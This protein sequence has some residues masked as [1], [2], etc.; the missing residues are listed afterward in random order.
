[1]EHKNLQQHVVD[2]LESY[3]KYPDKKDVK[4]FLIQ[5]MLGSR[6]YTDAAAAAAAAEISDT[7]DG[8]DEAYRSLQ[9]GK[10]QGR[11]RE[12][13]LQSELEKVAASAP[14]GASGESVAEIAASLARA[15][16][17][18]VIAL[19]APAPLFE[20]LD[21]RV[22]TKS[23]HEAVHENAVRGALA[24]EESLGA[25]GS[26]G[27]K[28]I[29]A[30]RDYLQSPLDGP[31]DAA[32][33]K[34]VSG[35]VD[36]SRRD[37]NIPELKDTHPRD[38][39]VMVDQGVTVAKVGYKV[40]TGEMAPADVTDYLIDKGASRVAAVLRQRCST[41]GA[42]IGAELGAAVGFVFGPVGAMVGGVVGAVVGGLAGEKV[43]DLVEK[44]IKKVAHV[45][46]E[47]CRR[48]VEGLREGVRKTRDFLASL[49]S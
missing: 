37:R 4:K 6:Q 36:I 33:K 48:A 11:S 2:V 3:D 46:K 44:G 1:M 41:A 7:V 47:T 38:I 16:G 22:I 17:L 43:G 14:I 27:H 19:P 28:E 25:G 34:L 35:A 18:D 24:V 23:I 29:K 20:G 9:A 40:A 21:A 30:I 49:L 39:A 31:G 42:I 32:F 8:I 15:N 12:T 10:Q 5:E 13:W 26:I 45:A